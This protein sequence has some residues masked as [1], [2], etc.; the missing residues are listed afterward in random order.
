EAFTTEPLSLAQWLVC[1]AMASTVLWASEIRKLI[2]RF[3]DTRT[4]PDRGDRLNA[5]RQTAP[6]Q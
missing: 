1:I 5:Q 3:L 6:G 2:L 4:R